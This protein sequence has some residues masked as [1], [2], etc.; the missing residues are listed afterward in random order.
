MCL[1]GKTI[2]LKMAVLLIFICTLNAIPIELIMYFLVKD[3]D[4]MAVVVHLEK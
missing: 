1:D 3:F 4:K 2:L